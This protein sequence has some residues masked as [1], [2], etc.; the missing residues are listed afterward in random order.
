MCGYGI[1]KIRVI[2]QN[3]SLIYLGTTSVQRLHLR[4]KEVG[5]LGKVEEV[6]RTKNRRKKIKKTFNKLKGKFRI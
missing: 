3:L 4:Q 2:R 5:R 6:A 1:F